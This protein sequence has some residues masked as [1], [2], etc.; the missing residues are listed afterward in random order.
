MKYSYNAISASA[1]SGKTYTLAMRV[2]A[3]CLK[4]PNYKE[5]QHILALTFTNK[6]ANEMKERILSWLESFTKDDYQNNGELKSIQKF[7][8]SQG[9]RLSLEDLHH[10]A[11]KVLDYILHHYSVLNI[12]TIDKFNSKLVRSFSYE[13]GLAQNFNLEI[14]NEPYLIEAVEQLLDKIGE[15]QKVSDA[16]MDFVT[17]NLEQEERINVNETLYSRAKTFVNDVHYEELK[18]NENFDWAA[19][20]QL[21]TQLR[22]EIEQY[23]TES[24]ALVAQTLEL[25]KTQGLEIKDFQGGGQ[26]GLG[27]FFNDVLMYYQGLRDG[28]PIPADEEKALERY[29]KGTASKDGAIIAAV[30]E[31]LPQLLDARQ[32]LI[33]YYIESEK[34]DKVLKELLPLKINKEISEQLALI[35]AEDDLVLLSKFNILI[36]ENLRTEPSAFIYEKIGTKFHHY[37]FD[38][39]QDTSKLQWENILPLRDHAIYSENHSFT[40]VGDPK[41]SI[42]R[43]RGGDSEQMLDIINKTEPLGVE[44]N[45]ENLEY[46][47]RSAK[48]IVDFNNQL[49]AFMAK[50]LSPE[51][52]TLFAEHGRQ[53][54]Q[55]TNLLGRVKVNLIEYDRSNSVYFDSVA[56]QMLMN[57]KE[58][59]ANGFNFS[60]ICI[61]CRT[62][63]EIQEL[64]LRLGKEQLEYKGEMVFLKTLSEKGLTLDLSKTLL[65]VM[66]YLRWEND[67]DN[68]QYLVRLLYHLNDLG[69]ITI[70]NFTEETLSI[71]EHS[72]DSEVLKI[73]D[74]QFGIPFSAEH[75]LNFNL[76]NRIEHLVKVCSVEDKETDY[77]LN[78]LE[79]VY[80]F[81][82]NGGRN[83]KDFITYWDEEIRYHSI[84]TSENIDA[85]KMMTIHSAKG[86]EYPVV[87][88][89]MKNSHKDGMFQEWFSVDYEDLKS[90][91]LSQFK[92]ELIPYDE[93]LQQFSEEN[94]Y[95]NKIDRF[96]VQYVAT[97]RPVEQLFLYLQKPSK[98]EHNKLELLDFV[99]QCSSEDHFDIYP[100]VEGSYKKQLTENHTS[101]DLQKEHIAA[102]GDRTP[103]KEAIKIAT[104]SKHYQ[105]KNEKVKQGIFIHEILSQILT[106][107][108]IKKVL[109]TYLIEG[110]ISR[111]DYEQI[112]HQIK[113]VVEHPQYAPYFEEVDEVINERDVLYN[114]A[115]YRP[116]RIVR[117]GEGYYIIDFK[118]GGEVKKNE[119][120]I[121][122]YKTILE[123]MGKTV[124]ATEIIY[125]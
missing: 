53:T 106:K 102:F 38:E 124:L 18:K 29:Q 60:D 84:Q 24:K 99:Q 75:V 78:F 33:T 122:H 71:L 43:F 92:K 4:T 11:K 34:R 52:H 117:K 118:T 25:I 105:N 95:R 5:I 125:L 91:N 49:Y 50:D 86:L 32:Q 44:I 116:D 37:F 41:Q 36:K 10:R 12:S 74:T 109:N 100:E 64:S 17:Y 79:E 15:D 45:I 21:K 67:R 48:N 93:T 73:L 123:S 23:K 35:E 13:L 80:A 40:L 89:P 30:E 59:L 65:A 82:Q 104:P 54:P 76:Y 3:I 42:Y 66:D 90:V 94:I 58:C 7:L 108:D 56:E 16:F 57:I 119:T 69:R 88:L 72:S 62:K 70:Q 121:G 26:S 107:D 114:G 97:T 61:L 2:L 98:P 63:S 87:F 68:R 113:A 111:A 110:Q 112:K 83:I 51:H 22:K 103:H 20:E 27:K 101:E 85:V 6:A 47:W 55:K 39:F 77:L 1:G 120:Q 9:T 31:I 115:F 28:F 81:T 46:N 19:Y 96:C 14:N 8:A